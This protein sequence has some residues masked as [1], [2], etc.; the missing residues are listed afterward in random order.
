MIIDNATTTKHN[1]GWGGQTEVTSDQIILGRTI[2]MFSVRSHYMFWKGL[3]AHF[4]LDIGLKLVWSQVT[5]VWDGLTTEFRAEQ[6]CVC[7]RMCVYLCVRH[8]CV[9]VSVCL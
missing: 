9:R 3:R 1:P 7:A 6:G 8:V 2:Y 5:W 4:C